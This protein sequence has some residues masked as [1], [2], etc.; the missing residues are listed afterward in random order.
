M[1]SR[2]LALA[3]LVALAAVTLAYA[4]HFNNG[5]HF[6]DFHTV[7]NNPY[8]RS[9]HNAWLFFRDPTT[10]SVLPANRT[11]RPLV[12]LSVAFDYW[13]AGGLKPFYFHLDMF[14][15]FLA[16]LAFMFLL[17]R[18][19]LRP[20]DRLRA[21]FAALFAVALYGLHPAMA[22]TVNYIIQRGDLYSTALVV[23]SLA[24]Y[25]LK[26]NLRRYG[27][28]LLP[29]AFALITKQPAAIFPA[30]LFAYVLLFE[31]PER[32]REALIAS[33][34]SL[35]VTL[36][37]LWLQ[38]HMLPATY[39][40]GIVSAHD[41]IVTQPWIALHYF[42]M[43]FAPVSLT[44]DTDQAAFSTLLRPEGIA[45]LLFLTALAWAIRRTA[46]VRELRPVS[47]GLA[48]FLL[49]L[50]PTAVYRLSEVEN[51]HR[52]FLPF[53]GL[54]LA[55]GCGGML[56]V[57]R[58]P[59]VQRLVWATAAVA[60]VACAWGT[61]ERNSV[62]REEAS[63]WRDVTEK[64][65]HNGRGLMNYGLTLMADGRYP[66]SLTYFERALQFTPNYAILEINLGID[67]GQLHRDAEAEQ[68]FRRAMQL[69]PNDEQPP[70]YYGR[71]LLERAR[72][73][74]A[75]G[76][77]QRS[78]IE[79]RDYLEPRYALMDAYSRLGMQSLAKSLAADTLQMAP[80]DARA[81]MYYR[82]Q[83]VTPAKMD[84]VGSAEGAVKQAPTADNY[85]N[86][87]LAYHRAG[88]F[89]ECIAAAEQAL[90]LRPDYA[91]AYN[92]IAAAHEDLREWDAAISAAR[93]AV[94]LKPDF[95]LAKNNLAYSE[96]QKQAGAK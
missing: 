59:R 94:R 60:L 55:A 23:A 63:L 90:R 89:R 8:V 21:G 73:A 26:P 79:N 25:A 20:V 15:W 69:A 31:K 81:M 12:T 62:W 38:V 74:E 1:Q 22:E 5:F 87:S 2:K 68:H 33:L 29:L 30:L 54:T 14:V 83:A 72:L 51:D 46:K 78:I 17:F 52:M 92:N 47:F 3:A 86:L 75:I 57:A 56:L 95:Q 82:G 91:E 41:Y 45:G 67:Y 6:D 85:L 84:P 93:E 88:R 39:V 53:V 42:L 70:F 16:Q 65:P 37:M 11:Y 34:P 40:P 32:P 61:H 24:L 27:L 50:F 71:W 48:W 49:S 43:F 76:M 10:F 64:S 77:F 35:G 9:L 4:N 58:R 44:A 96:R 13:L 19:V 7:N 36:A 18:H 80:G 66:E 28:Y